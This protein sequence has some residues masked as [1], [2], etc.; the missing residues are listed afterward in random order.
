MEL[1]STVG[2]SVS[3][4]NNNQNGTENQ[5]TS[6]MSSSSRIIN[7]LLVAAFIVGGVVTPA[8][9]FLYGDR[10]PHDITYA[11]FIP[12]DM[13]VI[14]ALCVLGVILP[15]VCGFLTRRHTAQKFNTKWK[16]KNS[17]D[18]KLQRLR[19]NLR[20]GLYIELHKRPT[21]PQLMENARE[22]LSSLPPPAH[23][24]DQH[25][26][27][28]EEEKDYSLD[29]DRNIGPGCLV[30]ESEIR[31]YYKSTHDN[32]N[33]DD[34]VVFVLRLALGLLATGHCTVDVETTILKTVAV[35]ELAS[36]RISVGHRLL[37]A[38]FGSLPP[39][40]L[41]CKRDFVFSTLKDLQMLADA[42]IAGE[43]QPD[44]AHVALEV[45]NRILDTPLPYGWIMYDLVFIGIDEAFHSPQTVVHGNAHRDRV[46]MMR[47][48]N[49]RRRKN[50][51]ADQKHHS[52][53]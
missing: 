32:D 46:N 34:K 53:G 8:F 37:Q 39:H 52:S 48:F 5:T 3:D 16:A 30:K 44:E 45:C 7:L 51:Y 6:P 24:H 17:K 35:L 10:G 11:L 20:D 40:L 2:T 33:T 4:S 41:T 26:D 25:A 13:A 42:V 49:I 23:E 21:I 18:T 15:V 50:A 31:S 1:G 9:L 29:K 47:S 14:I 27:G 36:P 19:Q 22:Y 43:I 28:R 38:Q 12:I